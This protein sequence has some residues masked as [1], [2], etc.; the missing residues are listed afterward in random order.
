M[1]IV[2][3][4]LVLAMYLLL[5]FIDWVGFWVVLSGSGGFS[6]WFGLGDLRFAAWGLMNS[7][8]GFRGFAGCDFRWFF[9]FR[10]DFATDRG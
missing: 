6:V 10:G 5:L 9:R 2:L 8:C 3:V 1:C 7:G 4:I